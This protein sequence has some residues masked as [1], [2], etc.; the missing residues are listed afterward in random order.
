MVLR[1][2]K[3]MVPGCEPISVVTS[4]TLAANMRCNASV[5]DLAAALAAIP[6]STIE[7]TVNPRQV[8]FVL[9]SGPPE[10]PGLCDNCIGKVQDWYQILRD[11]A[12][13][14]PAEE[15][16]PN[17]CSNIHLEGLC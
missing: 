12:G 4:P 14:E 8:F 17:E 3:I 7:A 6:G 11:I 9:P 15:E 1:G 10:D 2:N 5:V 13:Q 16:A